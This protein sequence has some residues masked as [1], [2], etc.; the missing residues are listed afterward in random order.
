M[1]HARL[2]S[3]SALLVTLVPYGTSLA[4]AASKES[5]YRCRDASGQVHYGD[6]KPRECDG[7]DTEVLNANGIVM[8]VIEGSQ[9][10][11]ERERREVI[12]KRARAERDA[13]LQRDRMLIETYLTVEDIERLR[14]QRLELLDSRY[15]VAEQ[16]ISNLRDSQAR[17]AQ[18]VARFTGEGAYHGSTRARPAPARDTPAPPDVDEMR[19]TSLDRYESRDGGTI[20]TFVARFTNRCDTVAALPVPT[21]EAIMADGVTF[22]WCPLDEAIRSQADSGKPTVV[23]E[24]D[25]PLAAVYRRIARRCAVKIAE[26]QRDMTSKFPN[27]VVQ[28]T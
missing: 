19:A 4:A 27:I 10:R 15:R 11:A 2:I 14:D 12:E 28:N 26:S 21:Q 9:T 8:R 3:L 1:P 17:L 18:Q 23:S 20:D 7:L 24:P 16:N 13:K 25:G 5:F 22:C 6:S